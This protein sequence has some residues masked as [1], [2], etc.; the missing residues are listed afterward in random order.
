MLNT[1]IAIEKLKTKQKAKIKPKQRIHIKL[2]NGINV[3]IIVLSVAL[4]TFST[5][6]ETKLYDNSTPKHQ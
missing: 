2:Q 4:V 5:S 3:I 6:V 1:E